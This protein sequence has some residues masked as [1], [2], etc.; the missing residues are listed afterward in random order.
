[1]ALDGYLQGEIAVHWEPEWQPLLDLGPDVIDDFMW[2]GC[3]DLEDGRRLQAYKHYWTR[4]YVHLDADGNAFVY[5][6]HG[7]LQ[8][9]PEWELEMARHDSVG[10]RY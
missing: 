7:Y 4:R 1:M 8:G 6:P 10:K 2:M 3:V 9:D 5:T